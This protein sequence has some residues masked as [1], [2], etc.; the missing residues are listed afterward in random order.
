MIALPGTTFSTEEK[1][2]YRNCWR[3]I[4]KPTE[5]AV[6]GRR[7]KDAA[8]QVERVAWLLWIKELYN[9]GPFAITYRAWLKKNST[10]NKGIELELYMG[11]KMI[12]DAGVH[13][14]I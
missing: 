1:S 6:K 13:L 4:W 5:S 9:C 10:V 11:L 3:E 7:Q 12:P 2:L 14:G 8:E